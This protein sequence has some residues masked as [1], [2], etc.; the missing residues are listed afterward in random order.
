MKAS[1]ESVLNQKGALCLVIVTL[2]G[3]LEP[4]EAGIGLGFSLLLSECPWGVAGQEV[5][6]AFTILGRF[7]EF[8]LTL[9]EE[10]V[11]GPH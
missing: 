1:D 5:K 2:D 8:R 9:E 11:M 3:V 10:K 4:T 6:P 7:W